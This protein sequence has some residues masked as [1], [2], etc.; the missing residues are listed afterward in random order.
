M[1]A[2][3]GDRMELAYFWSSIVIVALP[4]G[5]FIT[6]AVLAVRGSWRELRRDRERERGAGS[7][8]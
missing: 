3:H 7:G 8:T 1:L 5:V 6:I 2:L 4:V